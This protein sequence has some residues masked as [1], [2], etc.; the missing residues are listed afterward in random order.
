ME[1][2]EEIKDGVK[3][4]LIEFMAEQ[5]TKEESFTDLKDEFIQEFLSKKTNTKPLISE[6][7]QPLIDKL[8]SKVEQFR[9]NRFENKESTIQKIDNIKTGKEKL[10]LKQFIKETGNYSDTHKDILKLLEEKQEFYNVDS[11]E[12][13]KLKY[14]FSDF[15]K[16]KFKNVNLGLIQKYIESY[17][18]NS[19]LYE[20]EIKEFTNG[21]NCYKTYDLANKL[22]KFK[23]SCSFVY[24]KEK[25][26]KYIDRLFIDSAGLLLANDDLGIPFAV[27]AMEIMEKSQNFI[28]LRKKAFLDTVI[29]KTTQ[30]ID[31]HV[32]ENKGDDLGEAIRNG[33]KNFDDNSKSITHEVV[34]D[35]MRHT[36]KD[37]RIPKVVKDGIVKPEIKKEINIKR[38]V[39]GNK[40][41]K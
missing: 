11:F 16:E 4:R 27:E 5:I 17:V 40:K 32:T 33:I 14:I 2:R 12:D 6:D 38:Q 39:K 34:Q 7:V 25:E 41:D 1:K 30:I 29:S 37:A 20:F 21:D 13:P 9:K 19:E 28:N 23:F 31:K 15:N 18:P 8:T 24:N 22:E 3:Q 35:A 36:S 26:E 10:N